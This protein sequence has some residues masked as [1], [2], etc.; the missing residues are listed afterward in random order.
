M[1][2]QTSELEEHSRS[3]K[4]TVFNFLKFS[5]GADSEGYLGRGLLYEFT[6]VT[7]PV[8][9]LGCKRICVLY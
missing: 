7:K 6:T 4:Y 2:I 9:L 5:V 8:K 1:Y 3:I